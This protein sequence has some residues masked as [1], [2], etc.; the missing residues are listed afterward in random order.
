[1]RALFCVALSLSFLFM[2]S[3]QRKTQ[4]R[5]A[6]KPKTA[7]KPSAT[8]P[9]QTSLETMGPPPP[10]PS[11]KKPPE[12]E[13]SPGDIVSVDTTEVMFPVTVRDTSGQLINNLTRS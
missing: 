8:P 3:A 5:T 2:A 7:A 4:R 13:V 11:L 10:V 6:P 1:M 12:Q 9:A